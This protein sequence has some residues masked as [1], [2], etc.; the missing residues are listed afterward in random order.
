MT[1][2][3]GAPTTTSRRAER[4]AG[5]VVVLAGVVLLVA[6]LMIAE[7]VRESPGMGPRVLPGI[8]SAG[9]IVSGL[10]LVLTAA[11]RHDHGLEEALLGVDDET[12]LMELMDPDEPPVPWRGLLVVL[13]SLVVYAL[14][15]IPV[16]FL[17]STTLFLGGIT[18]YADPRRWLRNW[19]FAAALAI[20]VYLL[21]TRVLAVVLPAGVLG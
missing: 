15:F 4:L 11:R 17:L 16:G 20:S 3:V 19:V 12:H 10:L 13:A 18:T 5:V 9:L 7:P 2:A 6:T 8:V 1:E 21:F 14:I